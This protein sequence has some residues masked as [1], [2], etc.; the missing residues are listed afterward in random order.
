MK[1]WQAVGDYTSGSRPHNFAYKE[2]KSAKDYF[3][4]ARYTREQAQY[5]DTV[6]DKAFEVQ[7]ATMTKKCVLR[8]GNAEDGLIGLLGDDIDYENYSHSM[9][10]DR[11]K[12]LNQKTQSGETVILNETGYFSTSP[13][14]DGGFTDKP[15]EVRILCL[16]GTK[17]LYVDDFSYYFG[18]KETIMKRNQKFKFVKAYSKDIDYDE[19]SK[20]QS[21]TSGSGSSANSCTSTIIY[22]HAIPEYGFTN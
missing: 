3:N 4:N 7:S 14:N 16:P 11:L 9:F 6:L 8:H 20:I 12:Q 10:I 19:F 21:Q 22:L 13:F 15:V 2:N 17:G 18:E 5:I 1:P